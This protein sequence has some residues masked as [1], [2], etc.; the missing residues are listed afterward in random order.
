MGERDRDGRVCRV[1]GARGPLGVGLPD[2]TNGMAEGTVA[3]G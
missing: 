1:C 2:S 3:C